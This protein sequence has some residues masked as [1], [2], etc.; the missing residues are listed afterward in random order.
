MFLTII[1]CECRQ[2]IL[3]IH[4]NRGKKLRYKVNS[5]SHNWY[6]SYNFTYREQLH[7]HLFHTSH[8]LV[9]ELTLDLHN[10]TSSLLQNHWL[11]HICLK[12][13]LAIC[14]WKVIGM[15]TKS[16]LAICKWKVIDMPT[17]QL[18]WRIS[19]CRQTTQVKY[20]QMFSTLA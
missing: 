12:S 6:H 15:P 2:F 4:T 14:K 9:T 11:I 18:R 16:N 5:Q 19:H 3:N 10:I 17:I 20:D 8:F 1:F 7:K 13:N